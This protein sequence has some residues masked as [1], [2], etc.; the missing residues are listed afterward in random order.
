[1]KLFSWMRNIHCWSFNAIHTSYTDTGTHTNSHRVTNVGILP[2]WFLALGIKKARTMNGSG[3]KW[4]EMS[5]IIVMIRGKKCFNLS[6]HRYFGVTWGVTHHI[7]I[8]FNAFIEVWW[9]ES[10]TFLFLYFWNRTK[11]NRTENKARNLEE[12]INICRKSHSVRRW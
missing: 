11:P 1:M 9:M 10:S 3:M 12:T 6:N 5:D 8:L 7:E 4:N 2:I